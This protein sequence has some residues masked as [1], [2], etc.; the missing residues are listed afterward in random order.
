MDP[1][2]RSVPISEAAGAV[3]VAQILV[4]AAV[5]VYA[6]VLAVRPPRTRQGLLFGIGLVAGFLPV[7]LGHVAMIALQVR[8]LGSGEER[9][10]VEGMESASVHT[11]IGWAVSAPA[12]VAVVLARRR[13]PRAA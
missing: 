1:T 12:I 13:F 7:V 6:I 8:A 2:Y 5:L 3:G 10:L 9:G 11:W 4:G